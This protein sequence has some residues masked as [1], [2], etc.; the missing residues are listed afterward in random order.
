MS[1]KDE[2]KN[3]SSEKG[4]KKI[5]N[6]NVSYFFNTKLTFSKNSCAGLKKQ[7]GY[8]FSVSGFFT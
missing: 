7:V 5:T 6:I 8:H 1:N 3:C 2:Y 4:L